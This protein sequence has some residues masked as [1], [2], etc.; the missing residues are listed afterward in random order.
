ME[1][2][3]TACF[4]FLQIKVFRSL[5]QKINVSVANIG[6]RFSVTL[7]TSPMSKQK[8]PQPWS[9]QRDINYESLN[10]KLKPSIL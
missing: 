4:F 1:Y 2:L 5:Y 9:K 8:S 3:C 10:P 7:K 6:L